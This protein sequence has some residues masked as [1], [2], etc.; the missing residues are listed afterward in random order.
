MVQNN[1]VFDASTVLNSGIKIVTFG[2]DYEQYFYIPNDEGK[3]SFRSKFNR[4]E[5]LLINNYR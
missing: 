3:G 4:L 5:M 2:S 1:A